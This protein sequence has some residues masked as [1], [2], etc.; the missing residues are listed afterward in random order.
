VIPDPVA[1]DA[2][3][4]D[5][6]AMRADYRAHH[7]VPRPGLALAGIAFL[8]LALLDWTRHWPISQYWWLPLF[9]V[10]YIA[11][12][13]R[14][15]KGFPAAVL[16]SG[17]RFSAAGLDVDV[18]FV[19]NPRR[20]YSWRGMRIDDIGELFVLV[21]SFGKRVLI[22]KRSFPDGGHEAW[23]FFTANRVAGRTPLAPVAPV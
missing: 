5:A 22:P 23:A 12:S 7:R 6:E 17:L 11:F 20:H 8:V 18:P 3:E 14:A 16:P 1:V 19:K 21:P 9:G 15:G 10:G 2:N 13:M 4:F